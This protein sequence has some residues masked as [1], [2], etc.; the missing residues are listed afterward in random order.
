MI[1]AGRAASLGGDVLLMEKNKFLGAKLR[2]TGKGRCNITNSADIAR[3]IEN[4]AH[5]GKFLYSAFHHFDNV[6]LITFFKG[7]GLEV[8]EE[9]GGRVFPL[10]DKASD[11]VRVLEK[12]MVENGVII[13]LATPASKLL[14]NKEGYISGVIDTFKREY[15]ADCVIVATGGLSYPRT[16]STG[17][18]YRLARELGHRIV[19][20]KPG[21]VPLEIGDDWVKELQGLSLRNVNAWVECDR[22]KIA[23]EF[24]EMLFTH[25]GVSGPII[26]TLSSKIS[27]HLQINR[28]CSLHL[29]L[30]PALDE[31]QLDNRI[32]RDF[33]KFNRK[34]F[35]NALDELLPKKIIPII[36]RLSNISP[37][38]V[39]GQISR[40]ERRKIVSL[41]KDFSMEVVGTRPVEEAIITAG[42]IHVDEINPKTMESKII[43]GLFFAG[44]VIDID[45]YTGGYNLQ[46]A[47]STGYLAGEMAVLQ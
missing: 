5:N 33:A 39:V 25:F 3:F 9:R 17:E 21:L 30:K 41:L 35:K 20:P 14:V 13:K 46:A 28:H 37:E 1:A 7:L 12:Y 27:K 38:K 26:L 15:A 18:G 29:D 47:F 19:A 22:E 2:I 43:K 45:A 32:Q 24:G 31:K 42:G 8:K 36:I 23:E 16:G 11:V 4:F 34:Q 10:T 6:S 40:E 44:E